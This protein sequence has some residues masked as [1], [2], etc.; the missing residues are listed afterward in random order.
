MVR[1]PSVT[2][3]SSVMVRFAEM[4]LMMFAI[5]SM[6]LGTVLGV[7]LAAVF[8]VPSALRFQ[9]L[10]AEAVRVEARARMAAASGAPRMACRM[11]DLT[12]RYGLG[13]FMVGTLKGVIAW[14]VACMG[15][16]YATMLV[17]SLHAPP[18]VSSLH[19]SKSLA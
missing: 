13:A 19:M 3:K 16:V 15:V 11:M 10:W 17:R 9:L 4:L 12:T 7:Q 1:L 14:G 2:A 8:Q 5:A 6:L 18:S